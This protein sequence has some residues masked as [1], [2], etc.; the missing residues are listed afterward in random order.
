MTT[1]STLSRYDGLTYFR[2][3]PLG[4]YCLGLSDRYQPAAYP[5][6][7]LTVLPNL[8]VVAVS[9]LSRADLMLNSFLKSVSD[10]VW[11]LEQANLL[12]RSHMVVE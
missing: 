10:V 6:T 2:L 12:M 8:E 3:T 4:A 11:K 9:E 7:G 5:K 1:E